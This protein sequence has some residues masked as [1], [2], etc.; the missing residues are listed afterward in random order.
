MPTSNQIFIDL[1]DFCADNILKVPYEHL[2][3]EE[4][5]LKDQVQVLVTWYENYD[6]TGVGIA[7][8]KLKHEQPWYLTS[9]EHNLDYGPLKYFF[10]YTE[11]PYKKLIDIPIPY[12]KPTTDFQQQKNKQYKAII[13]YLTEEMKEV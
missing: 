6:F 12:S 10:D 9:L 1:K 7:I 4:K 11:G 5:K 2:L 13:K 3:P 8:F